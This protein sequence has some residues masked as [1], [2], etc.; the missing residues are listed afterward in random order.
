[1]Q[2]MLD[3]THNVRV[4]CRKVFQAKQLTCPILQLIPWQHPPRAFDSF[5][6]YA[7]LGVEWGFREKRK[8][9]IITQQCVGSMYASSAALLEKV[10]TAMGIWHILFTLLDKKKKSKDSSKAERIE[11]YLSH[12]TNATLM[13]VWDSHK[14]GKA[15][16]SE[17]RVCLWTL[18]SPGFTVIMVSVWC[19]QLTRT[20]FCYWEL[21]F[22]S[23]WDQS[24]WNRNET[25]TSF[26]S[27]GQDYYY[28]TP[29]SYK[30]CIFT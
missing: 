1:M 26:S 6:P 13:N 16:C 8:E 21:P 2:N 18:G 24:I 23:D 14:T 10:F 4:V 17:E 19:I 22:I 5:C 29:C 27:K 12:A 9:Y 15:S 7:C 11:E 20:F 25:V 28:K 3:N 30:D